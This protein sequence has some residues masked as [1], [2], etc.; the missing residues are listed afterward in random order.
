[1]LN[2]YSYLT[3]IKMGN[4]IRV[5]QIFYQFV[6]TWRAMSALVMT[7]NAIITNAL[8][9]RHG[10]PCP[11]YRVCP[12]TDYSH[13]HVSM[14]QCGRL[15]AKMKPYPDS[16]VIAAGNVAVCESPHVIHS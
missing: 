10:S 8:A 7:T 3:K 15:E 1:M 14:S 2:Y 12:L 4:P 16:T 5:A 11:Y 6:G 9:C 13:W